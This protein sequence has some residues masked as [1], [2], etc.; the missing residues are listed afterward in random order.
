MTFVQLKPEV[1]QKHLTV[2]YTINSVKSLSGW[3]RVVDSLLF[4]SSLFVAADKLIK[5]WGAYDGKFEKTISGHKLVSVRDYYCAFLF[6][7]YIFSISPMICDTCAGDI[8][9]GLVLW[10]QPAGFCLWWQNPEDLGPELGKRS[11]GVE[12]AAASFPPHSIPR[13]LSFLV[14]SDQQLLWPKVMKLSSSELQ[15]N[16]TITSWC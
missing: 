12:T 4:F 6:P 8:W 10:L 1:G 14:K 9:C 16:P 15:P 13:R 5:I 2:F 7:A 3:C 11:D